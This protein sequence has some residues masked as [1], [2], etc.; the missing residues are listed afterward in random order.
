MSSYSFQRARR[1]FFIRG[2]GLLILTGD[3]VWGWKEHFKGPWDPT[4][5]PSG[6]ETETDGFGGNL[7]L[8]IWTYWD[9]VGGSHYQPVIQ[10]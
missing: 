9:Q 3:F 8:N 2:G 6:E 5:R 7:M 10:V 1:F 4:A